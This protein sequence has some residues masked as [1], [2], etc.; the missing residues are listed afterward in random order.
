MCL[1]I[2]IGQEI[3]SDVSHSVVMSTSIVFHCPTLC[4]ADLR[5]T[6]TC[7][8]YLPTLPLATN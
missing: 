7:I 3:P 8:I 1:N 2:V 4:H 6:R 5:C